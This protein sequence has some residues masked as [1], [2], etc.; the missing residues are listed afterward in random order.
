M[1]MS[2]WDAFADALS[3]ELRGDAGMRRITNEELARL[4]YVEPETVS[5]WRRRGR[6]KPGL[7][8][9]GEV[10]DAVHRLRD[11]RRFSRHEVYRAMGLLPREP[12]DAELFDNATRLVRLERKFRDVVVKAS[13]AGR[14]R[15][16]GLITEAVAELDGWAV[17]VWPAVEG[18]DERARLHVADRI[19]FRHTDLTGGHVPI[20]EA[21][22]WQ[23]R[24]LRRALLATHAVPEDGSARWSD[25]VRDS[26]WSI[27]HIGS[28]RDPLV[29]HAWPGLRSLSLVATTPGSWVHEVAALTAMALG[30]GLNTTRDY[31]M[32]VFGL[33]YARTRS[34]DRLRAHTYLMHDPPQR[35]V[36]SHHGLC[37]DHERVFPDV[38][39]PGVRYVL[40]N[41]SDDVVLRWWRRASARTVVAT[42][43]EYLDSRD[44]MLAQADGRSDVVVLDVDNRSGNAARWAQ[45]LENVRAVLTLLEDDGVAIDRRRLAQAHDELRADE[46]RVGAPLLDWLTDRGWPG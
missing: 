33:D 23:V 22:V 8:R 29:D 13:D 17:A 42:G 10:I 21:D 36:W 14:R 30:Y 19:D 6:P 35:E 45:A 37:D 43:A 20:T 5:N 32:D 28:P 40:L 3:A 26:A 9:L 15:G 4:L 24:R 38:P 7:D 2:A 12:S 16:V 41:E 44:R 11:G 18:P 34:W 31:A 25:D 46:P 1:T 27:V 39:L